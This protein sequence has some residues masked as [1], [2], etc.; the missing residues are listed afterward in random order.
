MQGRMHSTEANNHQNRHPGR[1][2][3]ACG[4]KYF[5]ARQQVGH[6]RLSRAALPRC[7]LR[8]LA[9]QLHWPCP[10][11]AGPALV[12]V[13][14]PSV[15]PKSSLKWTCHLPPPL[16]EV[17]SACL[18]LFSSQPIISQPYSWSY[19]LA[20]Q[21]SRTPP[22]PGGGRCDAVVPAVCVEGCVPGSLLRC[23]DFPLCQ[24]VPGCPPGRKK[25]HTD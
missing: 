4:Q 2:T 6:P 25:T 9:R 5:G 7:P 13:R 21:L 11:A 15:P 18:L 22:P 3:K 17:Q 1:R 24:Q 19:G 12:C 10:S 23:R 14:V 20:L 8:G 16:P